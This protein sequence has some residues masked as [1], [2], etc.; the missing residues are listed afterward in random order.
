MVLAADVGL[1]IE[2]QSLPTLPTIALNPLQKLFSE[3]TGRFVVTINPRHAPAVEK[4]LQGTAYA[5]VGKVSRNRTLVIKNCGENI[6][7]LSRRMLD[8]AF[9]RRFGG[10]V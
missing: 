9:G 8:R 6:I 3:S 4:M 1:D 7:T 5:C 2:L 10:L